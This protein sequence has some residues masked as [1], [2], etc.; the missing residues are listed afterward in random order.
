[1]VNDTCVLMSKHDVHMIVVTS[2]QQ[3]NNHSPD[4]VTTHEQYN[5]HSHNIRL[6]ITVSQ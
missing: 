1:M 4:I 5:N 3:Y 6:H 2:Q